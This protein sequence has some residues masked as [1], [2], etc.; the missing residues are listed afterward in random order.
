MY[1]FDV[2]RIEHSTCT[3]TEAGEVSSE[4]DAFTKLSH[5][6]SLFQLLTV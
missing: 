6:L 2:T 5:G 3:I 1:E 4:K